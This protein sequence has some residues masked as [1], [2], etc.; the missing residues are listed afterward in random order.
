MAKILATCQKH[1]I[2]GGIHTGSLERTQ[3]YLEQGFNLVNLGTDGA[4]MART[5][6]TELASAKQTAEKQR[7]S[8]GY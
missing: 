8:S 5:A 4:F 1:G 2:A 6:A 3:Q 7:E